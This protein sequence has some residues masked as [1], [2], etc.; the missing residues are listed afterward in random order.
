MQLFWRDTLV[1]FD[2]W[3][4]AAWDE[5]GGHRLRQEWLRRRFG[6]A[7]MA[8]YAPIKDELEFSEY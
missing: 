8:D 5:K 3:F 4:P 7:N 6:G 2:G 1:E